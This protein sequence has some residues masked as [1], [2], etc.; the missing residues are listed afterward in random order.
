MKIS[1][2]V[3]VYNGEKTIAKCLESIIASDLKDFE[4]IVVDDN[5]K[6]KTP[7]IIRSLKCDFIKLHKRV[8]A[9]AARNIGAKKAKGDILAFTDS[10]CIIPTNWL[11]R[12]QK[13][14]KKQK[15]VSAI[16]G[17]YK[18]P[19]KKNIVSL[20]SHYELL[21]RQRSNDGETDDI[22]SSNLA[23]KKKAFDK[24]GGF[25]EY[26]KNAGN[27]DMELANKLNKA[28]YRIFWDRRNNV[29]HY[30]RT[31]LFE[32][33]EQQYRFART[34]VLSV[35]KFP[36]M[37]SIKS[38]YSEEKIKLQIIITSLMI[39]SLF[40]SFFQ[41]ASL[42]ITLITI[43]LLMHINIEVISIIRKK[44]NAM[45]TIAAFGIIICRNIAHTTGLFNGIIQG[46]L[47]KCLNI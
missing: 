5:S 30:F 42:I 33:L 36:E 18:A 35:F 11:S 43:I 29:E 32:Y 27:E 13:I 23:V 47:N 19:V 12:I 21:F 6:D 8:G 22:I 26:L 14:F 1:V 4:L 25:N 38:K 24:V 15:R 28:G 17:G 37:L 41:R 2:I 20:F 39:A 7:S 16:T 34:I 40:A 3:P 45:F 9:G 10:D 31:N 44:E 46:C